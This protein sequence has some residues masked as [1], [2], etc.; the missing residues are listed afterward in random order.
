MREEEAGPQCT[1]EAHGR[2]N[3]NLMGQEACG[4][5]SLPSFRCFRRHSTYG[6]WLGPSKRSLVVKLAFDDETEQVPLFH[7][8]GQLGAGIHPIRG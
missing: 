7:Y 1:P 8:A 4:S 3:G 2:A 6:N 5:R